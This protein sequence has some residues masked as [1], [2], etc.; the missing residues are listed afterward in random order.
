MHP[1][2]LP[3]DELLKSCEIT[4]TRRSGPGG[5]HRNKVETAVVVTH[6]ST[7]IRGE[8]SEKRS[9]RLNRKQ[10]I[11]RLR[12]K[13]A[14]EI[15]TEADQEP[16]FTWRR[17]VTGQRIYIS[18]THEDFPGMLAEALN[19]LDANEY[20]TRQAAEKMGVK[21]TQFVKVLKRDRAALLIVN[22][23]RKTRGKHPLR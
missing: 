10:A 21:T 6:M 9:Q 11:F 7:K 15:R 2:Q 18:G 13:L 23:E 12:V 19:A 20:S 4:L 16:S 8:A 17:R 1:A 14:L 3:V 5:Q 22:R